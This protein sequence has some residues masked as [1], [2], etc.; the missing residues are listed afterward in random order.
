MIKYHHEVNEMKQDK[1][2]YN[3]FQNVDWMCRLAWQH[4]KRTLLFVLL[5][6]SLEVL[7]NLTQLYIAPQILT[8]V[9]RRESLRSLFITIGLFS[10]ALFFLNFAKEYVTKNELFSRVDVR[11]AIIG[12]LGKKC[13][14]TSYI[15]TMKPEYIKLRDKAHMAAEGNSEATERIWHTLTQLLKNVGGFV[16]YLTILSN[17]DPVLLIVTIGTCGVGFAVSCYTNNWEYNH[18]EEAENY[19]TQKRYVHSTAESL[20]IAKDIRI[21]GLQNWLNDLYNCVHDAYLDYRLRAE[22]VK[23]LADFTETILTVVRNSIA[24]VY[25]IQL[26]LR[27]NLSVGEFLLYF[28]AISAF[29]QWVMGILQ[30]SLI[31]QKQSMDI[32]QVREFLEF[33]EPFQFEGGME[34]PK[35]DMYELKLQDVS[36]CY[37]GAENNIINNLTLTVHPG[38]KLAI[39]GLNGAGKSTLVK[40]LCGLLDPTEGKVLLNGQDIR[41]FNRQEYYALFSAVF[42]EFSILDATVAENIAQSSDNIDYDKVNACIEQAG[43]TQAIAD[44]PNGLETH[45]GREVFLDGVLFSGGQIQ[46]LMLARA[47]YKD[48]AILVLDEPTASLD[49]IAEND[50]YLKYNNMTKGKTALF[51]SHRLAST[52]FCD[53]IILIADGGVAEEGTHESLL[54]LGGEYAKLFEVQSRYYREGREF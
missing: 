22:K 41:E 42:Q 29:T 43:L 5:M 17:L 53:R 13:N 31:L 46:R 14:T 28:T 49:P 12:M 44:L 32:S 6:S 27:E 39:V 36:F 21:F 19:Y 33:P 40:L 7:F 52:R 51:I 2:K 30:E 35:T 16:V 25:L 11:T 50:I 48:G 8:L 47:L 23:L 34:I 38:E 3:V 18:R 20:T 26:A 54:A 45:V 15:N 1:P 4:R 37:D 9:E 10:S 24:Y